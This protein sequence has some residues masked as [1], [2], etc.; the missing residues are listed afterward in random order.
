MAQSRRLR[1]VACC[2]FV[3]CFVRVVR[4]AGVA[5]DEELSGK[6]QSPVVTKKATLVH[7]EI[8]YSLEIRLFLQ[9]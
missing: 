5:P 1:V 6:A 4:P 3:I 8:K 7:E 2:M 9:S